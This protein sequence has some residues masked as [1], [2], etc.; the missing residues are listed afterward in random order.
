M[1]I[2]LTGG[3]TAGHVMPNMAIL[4][5]LYKYFDKVIYIG[6]KEKMES[7]ICKKFNVQFYHCDS[8]KFDRTKKLKN[9]SI[10]FKLPSYINQAK[11]I[12]IENNI[13]IVFSKGGYVAMPVVYAAK[14]LKIPTVCHESDYSLGLANKLNCRFA[15]GIITCFDCTCKKRN[16][17]VFENPIRKD[18]FDAHPERIFN[19]YN[20][21]HYTPILLIVGGSLGAKSINELVYSSLDELCRRYQVIHICG[22]TL[23]PIEHKNYIQLKYADNIQDFIAASD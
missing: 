21:N 23:K 22:N 20:L 12:L 5:D 3:G 18:F 14:Q 7:E 11:K 17:K 1:N 16:A 13:D 15:K 19:A 6:N 9:F 10:P 2:A 4:E 8:I